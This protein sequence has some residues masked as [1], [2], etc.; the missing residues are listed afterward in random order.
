MKE[1]L[2]ETTAYRAFAREREGGAHAALVVFADEAYLRPLLKECAKAFFGAEDGS[3]E[4]KLID[5]ES[6]TD[7]L[8]FPAA[9]EKLT[10]EDGARII[11]ESLLKPVERAKK[12]FV[13]DAFHTASAIV[14]NKLL[15]VL[16][17]PPA[18]VCFLLGAAAEHSVLPTVLSR[19]KL[20]TVP[21]FSEE[22]IFRALTRGHGGET[23]L[24]EAAAASGGIYSVA[25]SLLGGGGENFRLAEALL[26]GR[27]TE[28]L[29]REIGERKDKRAFLSALRL[30]L[31]DAAFTAA[32]QGRFAA[33]R[34]EAV[35][36][37]AEEYPLGCLLSALGFFS[38]AERET[39]FNANFGQCVL[40]FAMQTGKEKETWQRL[41]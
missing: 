7:C 22:E 18:H 36:A 37:I 2:R 35:R 21:P 31:R 27:D 39:Q 12:L 26:S 34:G 17:E 32:G 29:C 33:R 8:F 24:K 38:E 9:G 11:D 3:R 30:V 16:E 5:G 4:A 40:K 28:K 41:S 15:K 23:G 19:A 20:C 10:A 14:Q 13:L 25:E 6:F 1:L